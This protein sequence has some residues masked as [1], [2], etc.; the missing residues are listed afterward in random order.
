M[1]IMYCQKCHSV[2]ECKVESPQPTTRTIYF[3]NPYINAYVR[4]RTCEKCGDSFKTYEEGEFSFKAMRKCIEM[5]NALGEF[6]VQTW[7]STRQEFHDIRKN[8]NE[9]ETPE[10]RKFEGEMYKEPSYLN[11]NV[12]GKN[13]ISFFKN[14]ANGSDE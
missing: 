4:I 6:I 7:A 1:T 13:V 5:S 2:A 12:F 9:L 11:E 14:K 10:E 3:E 8:K